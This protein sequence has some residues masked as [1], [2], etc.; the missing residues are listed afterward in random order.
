MEQV[1]ESAAVPEG[2][3]RFY[4]RFSSGDPEAF[5]AGLADVP[6]VSVIGSAPDEGHTER[7]DWISTYAAM[8]AGEMRGTRLDGDDPRGWAEGSLGFGV[9]K[10]AFVLP[11]G[12]RLPTRLTGVLRQDEGEWKVVHLHFSVGVPDEEA[13][14]P[15]AG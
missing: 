4:E 10:P 12:N 9:D 6:G 1:E 2:M 3:L 5:A 7:G 8:M 15:A 11:D 13:I 14:E